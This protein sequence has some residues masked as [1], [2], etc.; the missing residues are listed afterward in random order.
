MSQDGQSS[1]KAPVSHR[2][3]AWILPAHR[4][5]WAAAMLHEA[6]YITPRRA[7]VAWVLSCACAALGERIAYELEHMTMNRRILVT[8]AAMGAVLLASS[9][10]VY[11][12]AKPYQRDRLWISLQQA[13]HA[14][15]VRPRSDRE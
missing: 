15:E 5:E 2:L 13:M 8:V 3:I 4:K 1:W 6:A 7:A 11:V 10:F 9:I 12:S 14:D